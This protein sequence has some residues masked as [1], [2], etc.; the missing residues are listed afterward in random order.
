MDQSP[1]EDVAAAFSSGQ[2]AAADR[3]V[4]DLCEVHDRHVPAALGQDNA[5][6]SEQPGLAE[7]TSGAVGADSPGQFHPLR[8]IVPLGRADADR[9]P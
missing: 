7:M 2:R 3:G 8:T 6:C 4:P 5:I 9:L 1:D